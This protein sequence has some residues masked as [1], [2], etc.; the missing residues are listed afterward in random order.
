[1]GNSTGGYRGNTAALR[2]ANELR[3]EARW[4]LGQLLAKVERDREGGRPSENRP[5]SGQ[6]RA[7]LREIGLNKNR[8]NECERAAGGTYVPSRHR[9]ETPLSRPE[10]TED[11]RRAGNF[12]DADRRAE[13]HD[14]VARRD[15][16]NPCRHGRV[17]A[18]VL[19]CADAPSTRSLATKRAPPINHM[20]GGS[21]PEGRRAWGA[22]PD[23]II[24]QL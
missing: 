10:T 4:K 14:A 7:Y 5:G 13:G 20:R 11:A 6:F 17:E 18:T 22:A 2:P 19:R 24:N 1:L 12:A 8:A 16:V 15:R 23:E 9:L 21:F 3:F